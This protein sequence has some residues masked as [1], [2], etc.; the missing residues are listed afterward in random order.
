AA[1][2]A[3]PQP[4]PSQGAG[5]VSYPEAAAYLEHGDSKG[6]SSLMFAFASADACR[7]FNPAEI[8]VDSGTGE[9]VIYKV[10]GLDHSCETQVSA[11]PSGAPNAADSSTAG[12]TVAAVDGN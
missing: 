6:G 2:P 4:S 12:G 11:S 1:P 7:K 8:K 10:G 3:S 9:A 5:I